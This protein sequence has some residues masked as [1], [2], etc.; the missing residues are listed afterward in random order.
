M[1]RIASLLRAAG[2]RAHK[3]WTGL[4]SAAKTIVGNPIFVLLVALATIL[5][6]VPVVMSLSGRSV[7]AGGSGGMSP[8]PDSP[9]PSVEGSHTPAPPDPTSEPPSADTDGAGGTTQELCLSE[10]R[11]AISCRSPHTFQV[12]GKTEPG[13]S[14]SEAAKQYMGVAFDRVRG[15]LELL[16]DPEG[17][18]LI[19]VLGSNEL[20]DSLQGVGNRALPIRP[21]TPRP[22]AT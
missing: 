2:T 11:T 14:C 21:A 17:N 22:I 4:N 10:A 19:R 9:R 12:V 8:T 3:I 16:R 5:A 7:V 20:V 1:H 15:S 13:L 18:C 6:V